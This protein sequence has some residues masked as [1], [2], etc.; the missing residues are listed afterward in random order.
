MDPFSRF[1]ATFERIQR[2]SCCSR[3]PPPA[4]QHKLLWW[5]I[6]VR[7]PPPALWRR[8]SQELLRAPENMWESDEEQ[9]M[10]E[11]VRNFQKACKWLVRLISML[12]WPR[13]EY[14]TQDSQTGQWF[15]DKDGDGSSCLLLSWA[16]LD[17][18]LMIRYHGHSYPSRKYKGTL[19]AVV[20]FFFFFISFLFRLAVQRFSLVNG[21]LGLLSTCGAQAPHCGGF[22][23]CRA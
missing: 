4:P 3:E 14:T 15:L 17:C 12:I 7:H 13:G 23:C 2:D 16:E 18:F 9:F 1:T 19:R 20:L 22:S 6:P 10:L 21:K 11:T 5:E 8:G